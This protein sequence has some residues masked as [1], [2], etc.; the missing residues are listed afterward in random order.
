[1]TRPLLNDYIA[2]PEDYAKLAREL[3]SMVRKGAIQ[4]PIKQ[5]YHLKDA[6]RAHADLEARKTIGSTLLIPNAILSL[7]VRNSKKSS[8]FLVVL[9]FSIRNSIASPVPIGDKIRRKTH[10]LARVP[11]STKSSSFPGSRFCNIHCRE[12]P[13]ISELTI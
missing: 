3:F 11:L 5:T 6:R 2:K 7:L 13:F 8:L 4:I 1:M 10:I 12:S 9:S